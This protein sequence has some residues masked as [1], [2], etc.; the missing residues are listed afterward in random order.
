MAVENLTKKMAEIMGEGDLTV[1]GLGAEADVAADT[2]TFLRDPAD[3]D[4]DVVFTRQ[5]GFD[6]AG[7]LVR[8]DAWANSNAPTVSGVTTDQ[9]VDTTVT[10]GVLNTLTI[11]GTNYGAEDADLEVWLHVLPRKTHLGVHPVRGGRLAVPCAVTA[12]NVGDT[13]ITATVT[14]PAEFGGKV[15]AVG[16]CEL[17]VRN[18]KRQLNSGHVSGLTVV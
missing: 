2:L 1:A 4:S 9:A 13:E 16:V 6:A 8:Q 11:T 10:R 7:L 18:W 14:L 17:E 15:A 12:V 3:A 5:R